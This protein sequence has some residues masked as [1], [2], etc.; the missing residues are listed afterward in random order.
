MYTILFNRYVFIIIMV[1]L[2][3]ILSYEINCRPHVE[4]VCKL[5]E[6][7]FDTGDLLLVATHANDRILQPQWNQL[8]RL[9]GGGGE[10]NHAALIVKIDNE[11]YVY[12]TCPYSPYYVEYDFTM[13][14]HKD[15]GFVHLQK[16]I[17][18]L[19]GY[20]GIRKLK[21]SASTDSAL[22]LTFLKVMLNHN[23]NMKCYLDIMNFVTSPV[24][25]S[26]ITT[27]QYRYNCCEAVASIYHD[28]GI[29][30]DAFHAGM[31]LGP[32]IDPLCPL[33]GEIRHIVPGPKLSE[34]I[35]KYFTIIK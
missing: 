5:T 4:K 31:S 17:D 6:L 26:D 14:E 19:N 3:L 1:I 34:S 32:L 25:K 20:V 21:R 24:Y 9:I 27:L 10:W 13:N 15:S 22:S 2:L 11:P 23:V 12:D 18:T 33:F 28:A 7:H 30:Y 8:I 16:Y 29:H 35:R